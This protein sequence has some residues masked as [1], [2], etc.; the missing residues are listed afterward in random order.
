MGDFSM[1]ENEKTI[2]DDLNLI[3]VQT[4]L[5]S[6][7]NEMKDLSWNVASTKIL[8]QKRLIIRHLTIMTFN[9]SLLQ[10]CWI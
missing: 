4:T 6:I 2:H 5:S 8:S 7:W 1:K 3:H 10:R 9:R